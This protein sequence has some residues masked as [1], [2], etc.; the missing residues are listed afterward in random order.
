MRHHARK[1]RRYGLQPMIVINNDDQLPDVAA[2]LTVRA[3]WR[4]R[5][6]LAPLYLASTLALGGTVLHITQPHW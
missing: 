4:Y 1:M 2:A 3:L 5:P 6:E